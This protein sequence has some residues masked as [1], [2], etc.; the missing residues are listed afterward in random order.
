MYTV[1]A[2][3][4]YGMS[5]NYEPFLQGSY[6]VRR[7]DMDFDDNG[8][9]RD[10]KGFRAA[11]GVK[12]SFP[13]RVSAEVLAGYLHQ[14]YKDGKLED[15]GTPDFSARLHWRPAVSTTI[16]GYADRSLEETTLNGASGYLFTTG[17]ATI[18]HRLRPRLELN[19]GFSISESDFQG[20]ERADDLVEMAAG[21]SFFLSPRFVIEA[22]YRFLRR[23][24]TDNSQDYY[25]NQI[26]LRLRGQL[27][28]VDRS[29]FAQ[30]KVSAQRP[31][32]YSTAGGPYVGAHIGLNGTDTKLHGPREAGESLTAKLGD[33]GVTGGL[34]GG[35]GIALKRWYL[36]VDLEGEASNT[37]WEHRKSPDGRRFSVE[38]GASYG[39]G[40]R[41][42]RVFGQSSLLYGRVGAI[43]TNF[44][45]H[46][47]TGATTVNQDN[48]QTGLRYG[49]GAEVMATDRMFLRFDYSYT[50]YDEYDV[51]FGS[52]RDTFD[53]RESVFRAGLGYRWGSLQSRPNGNPLAANITGF[54]GGAQLGHG[55]LNTNFEALQR[56]GSGNQDL[57]ADFSDHGATWGLFGGYGII[58]DGWYVGVELEGE[59]S[60][61][62]WD[63]NRHP[64]IRS[65]SIE[66]NFSYGGGARI[67]YVLQQNALVYGRFGVVRTDFNT[68]YLK[69]IDPLNQVDRNDTQ[70]GIR[71]GVGMEIPTSEKVFIRL[72]YSYTDYDTYSFTTPQTFPDTVKFDNNESLF[73]LGLG[74]RL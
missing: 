47:A 40:A 41:L 11:A 42:G 12:L 57:V 1:G 7:Y 38:R 68:Q 74:I 6:D 5:L 69:G 29:R 23:D 59:A 66:K 61:A 73:R 17:G 51:D 9:K 20:I 16:T 56:E 63:Y 26:G 37:K 44:D 31:S 50:D 70:T 43:E 67:G 39:A 45:T 22:D 25:R 49:V 33:F 55:Q 72:D 27:Y 13:P 34:F 18:R 15:V 3:I 21:L 19:T 48:E 30:T 52:G 46:Y 65:F 28:T 62:R 32:S 60:Q 64:S 8:F 53:N 35:Y 10:S 36:G 71:F 14:D 58:E 2:R 54:F 4:G 24:S